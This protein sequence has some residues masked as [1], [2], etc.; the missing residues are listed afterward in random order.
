MKRSV[1]KRF[2]IS[3]A[4]A[5]LVTG[6]ASAQ[7]G[8][9]FT[10][11]AGAGFTQ[12]VGGSGTRL[13]TGWNLNG[14]AGYNFNRYVGALVQFDYN[15]MGLNDAT[16]ARVGTPGGNV[17]IWDFTL[18]PVVQLPPIFHVGAYVIGGGGVYHR[19]QEF[20]APGVESVVAFDPYFGFY[21]AGFPTTQIL[22]SYSVYKPGVNI[23]A[24]V[25]LGSKWNAKFYAE[26]RYHKIFT[27]NNRH[28]DYV[29]VTFG[30]RW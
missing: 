12:P 3:L 29:P 15:R 16:L 20:T 25:T 10:F 22:S 30:A 6:A 9:K 13:N 28:L 1:M 23:G 27:G 8:H 21:Q 11:N 4:A 19:T 7:E 24:G 18:N 5:L 14:G 2:G 26:A 17:N